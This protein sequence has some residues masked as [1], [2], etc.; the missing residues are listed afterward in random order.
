VQV[1]RKDDRPELQVVLDRNKLSA[2]GLNTAMVSS[3]LR[4]RVAGL[5]S[6]RL[7]EEGNEYDIVVRY[8]EEFRSSISRS[9][10]S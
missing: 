2:H 6:S 1:S 7:R 10:G 4:N 8:K 5:T 9:G 3:A